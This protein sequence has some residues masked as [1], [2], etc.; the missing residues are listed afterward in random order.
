LP[1]WWEN[2]TYREAEAIAGVGSP[3][4]AGKVADARKK[5]DPGLKAEK[6]EAAIGKAS[7]AVR[8]EGTSVLE[9]WTYYFADG[10]LTVNLSD[11]YVAR[12]GTEF[13]PPRI[14]KS[15]RP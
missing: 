5:V 13:G 15:R 12:V 9:I 14:R 11:G 2:R 3:V 1:R 10:T 4:L 8:T 7:F 6:V